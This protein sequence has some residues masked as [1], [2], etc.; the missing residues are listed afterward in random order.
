MKNF[1]WKAPVKEFISLVYTMFI[2]NN[3]SSFHLWWKENLVKHR[4]VSKYYETNFRSENCVISDSNRAITFA[5]TDTKLYVPVPTLS[6]QDYTKWLQQLKSGFK[7]TI[8]WNKYQSKIAIENHNQY[9]DYL[10]D[11]NFQGVIRF[12]V[13]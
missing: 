10:I 2:S 7:R 4:K 3:R 5:V 1:V 11:P 13:L 12:F 9:L 8:N 6:I